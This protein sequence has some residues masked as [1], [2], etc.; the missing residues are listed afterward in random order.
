LNGFKEREQPATINTDKAPAYE[1][2]LKELKLQGQCCSRLHH[3]QVQYLN[4]IV[5]Q[6]HRFIK[7]L[8]KH[9]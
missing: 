8:A 4:N 9:G 2:V 7:Y 6:D 1:G 3:R 5:E